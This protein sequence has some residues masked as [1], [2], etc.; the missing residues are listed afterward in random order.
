MEKRL[1]RENELRQYIDKYYTP[2]L[3]K[4]L[5]VNS[6]LEH[7]LS[8]EDDILSQISAIENDLKEISLNNE[9]PSI[10]QKKSPC[11][12]CDLQVSQY[13]NNEFT[14]LTSSGKCSSDIV[15]VN[16]Y[17]E[18]NTSIENNK[19]DDLDVCANNQRPRL[20]RSNSYVLESP[21]PMLIDLLRK[22]Q[23]LSNKPSEL[24]SLSTVYNDEQRLREEQSN[25]INV[26]S[27]KTIDNEY[28]FCERQDD[29]EHS[30][31]TDISKTESELRN[32][33]T[34]L[35]DTISNEDQ[36][37]FLENQSQLKAFID[38]NVPQISN[39]ESA[40]R[41]FVEEDENLTDNDRK[42]DKITCK[43]DVNLDDSSG[44]LS[45][46][47][48]NYDQ[49]SLKQIL[50]SIPDVYSKKILELLEKQKQEQLNPHDNVLYH[51]Q[52]K[53]E[54]LRYILPENKFASDLC[55][56]NQSSL[57]SDLSEITDKFKNVGELRHGAA[58]SCS[59]ELFPIDDKCRSLLN[60]QVRA[61]I[62]LSIFLIPFIAHCC[63]KK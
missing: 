44:A 55:T 39:K 26:S 49:K 47:L 24:V 42:E 53:L 25:V 54:D 22:Q 16:E 34:C 63:M 60:K 58:L 35:S 36:Q 18:N 38:N 59:R 12:S 8:F 27:P 30:I 2:S 28:I 33:S 43:S 11:L 37:T 41:Q 52:N 4:N 1:K 9:V 17:S 21:S 61:V 40:L 23:E 6:T 5:F 50:N 31:Y 32:I 3:E 15:A 19:D 29:A 62:F 57:C 48:S 56:R 45:A 7:K 13:T 14:V 46:E 10:R 20:V 51:E